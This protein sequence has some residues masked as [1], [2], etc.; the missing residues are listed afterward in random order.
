MFLIRIADYNILIKNQYGYI[1]DQCR[2]Y[3][4]PDGDPDFV[5]E[6]ADEEIA[7]EQDGEYTPAY[8][9]SI[10]VH[11]KIARA[12]FPH[13]SYVLHGVVI[14]VDGVGVAFLAQ[15]GTGKST[16]AALWK[17][18]LGEKVTVVNGDKP[19]IRRFNRQLAA[20]GTPWAGKE[21]EQT[22]KK[23]V[24]RKICFLERSTENQCTRL[25]GKD[26]IYRML[27]FVY[28]ENGMQ[29][30]DV[31]RILNQAEL[32]YYTLQCNMDVSAAETAYR[33]LML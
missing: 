14:E 22:N 29:A 4:I 11:R 33:E 17:K 19:I 12:L 26:M 25:S 15:S 32:E 9:E 18:L 24:L 2:D 21:H 3:L 27:P 1:R 28:T 7:A 30:L 8:L 6:A 23:C 20:Y 13:H 5:I 10:A 16:H 31:L